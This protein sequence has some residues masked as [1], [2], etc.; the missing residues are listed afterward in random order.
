MKYLRQFALVSAL[1][2]PNLLVAAP[3][4]DDKSA[5]IADLVGRMT[6]EEKVG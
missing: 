3:S 2:A 1:F 5:F 4:M 6:L